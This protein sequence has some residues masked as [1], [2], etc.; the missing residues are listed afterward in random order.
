M[1]IETFSSLRQYLTWTFISLNEPTFLFVKQFKETS[2][3]RNIMARTKSKQTLANNC[4]SY[5]PLRVSFWDVRFNMVHL[6]NMVHCLAPTDRV[7]TRL[8]C[9]KTYQEI[10]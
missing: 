3:V 7:I 4:F 5:T 1:L 2:I 8:R 6:T 9:I 10:V